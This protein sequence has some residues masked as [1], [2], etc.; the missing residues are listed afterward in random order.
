ME[1]MASGR[2]VV[3]TAV[4]DV[5]HLVEH[6]KT[7]FVVSHDDEFMLTE[8]MATL[9]TDYHLC[10]RM[11]KAAREKAE[12]EFGLECL[13]AATLAAYRSAGWRQN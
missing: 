5:P 4:G 12:R 3:A 9:M 10:A 11:G 7:G 6:G 13:V 8:N 2:A 1:A